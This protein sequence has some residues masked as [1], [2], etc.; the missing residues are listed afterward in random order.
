MATY[1]LGL[2]FSDPKKKDFP[3]PP[4]AQIYVKH[5]ASDERSTVCVGPICK[6]FFEIES[7]CDRLTKEI[8]SIR[9]KAQRKFKPI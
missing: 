3:G 6:S 5:Y 2:L 1:Y 9:K 8:A 7:L 4:A